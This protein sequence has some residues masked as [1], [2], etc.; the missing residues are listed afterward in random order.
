MNLLQ[1]DGSE[2]LT[3]ASSA[4][5]ASHAA[6]SATASAAT[7]TAAHFYA[8]AAFYA[9]VAATSSTGTSRWHYNITRE[10]ILIIY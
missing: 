3:A 10:I 1:N 4:F 8:G 2:F 5:A 6:T 9:G 7:A